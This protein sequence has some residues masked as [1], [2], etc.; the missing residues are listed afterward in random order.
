MQDTDSSASVK[1]AWSSTLRPVVVEPD[2]T[3]STT[4]THSTS[5]VKLELTPALY[6]IVWISV[7]LVCFINAIF[8]TTIA[9]VYYVGLAVRNGY[10]LEWM[11]LLPTSE[12][13]IVLALYVLTTLYF[14]KMLFHLIFLSI[15]QQRLIFPTTRSRLEKAQ[16]TPQPSRWT[17]KFVHHVKESWL[18][19]FAPGS[20]LELTETKFEALYLLREVTEMIT[21]TYQTYMSSTLISNEWVNIFY[22]GTLV[23]NCWLSPVIHV[24]THSYPAFQRFL[25]LCSDVVLDC[26]S[27]VFVPMFIFISVI[28]VALMDGQ[29]QTGGD[30]EYAFDV[31][32]DD[33]FIMD[34]IKGV[35]QTLVLTWLDV[36]T[37]LLPFL[38]MAGCLKHIM[39]LVFRQENRT[40]PRV[41]S[42]VVIKRRENRVPIRSRRVHVANSDDISTTTLVPTVSRARGRRLIRWMVRLHWVFILFFIWGVVILA[43]HLQAQRVSRNAPASSKVGCKSSSRP[44]LA[45]QFSCTILEINCC[46]HGMS[47]LAHEIDEVLQQVNPNGLSSLIISHCSS[48]HIPSRITD[49]PELTGL[50]ITNA[51]LVEWGLDAV[52]SEDTMPSL[53]M[54]ALVGVNMSALPEAIV[55]PDFPRRLRDL[56]ISAS[57]LTMLPDDLARKWSSLFNLFIERTQ[58]TL[59]APALD[60][61]GTMRL[62]LMGNQIHE[63]P[64]QLFAHSQFS[65]LSAAKNPVTKWPSTIGHLDELTMLLMDHTEIKELPSWLLEEGKRRGQSGNVITVSAGG[66]AYCQ[67]K[68][69]ETSAL[70]DE[71]V[72]GLK[73]VCREKQEEEFE[74]Y[75][76]SYNIRHRPV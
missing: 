75:P 8:A 27:T 70:I 22:V 6:R 25:Y 2:G 11:G 42:L 48:L 24:T 26:V 23:V 21:Q 28:F 1:R 53:Q 29:E 66:S 47:G 31:P 61:D 59:V 35:Q 12:I 72:T 68:K 37:K 56:T 71:S 30:T 67:A 54:L 40:I 44:W 65:V 3:L 36:F 51:T 50:E 39:R 76:L 32:Y 74:A 38:S 62:S 55:S 57:N 14:W 5:E 64:D 52:V 58:V 19:L 63:I 13:P 4:T 7:V 43:M 10:M 9:A 17:P 18:E 69:T 15:R 45:S 34:V 73:I 41:N 60:V 49:L 46:R 20:P 33:V 16:A